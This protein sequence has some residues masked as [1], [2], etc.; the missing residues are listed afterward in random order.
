MKTPRYLIAED[1]PLLARAL[2]AHLAEL[3]SEAECA[4]FAA[5]GDEALTLVESLKPDVIFLD[6]RM[7]GRD[8]LQTAQ[9]LC[10]REAPPLIVFATAYDEYA[11]AAF[12]AAAVDY[13]LKPIDPER[14]IRCI[15]RLRERLA[16]PE[17]APALDQL[18]LRLQGLLGQTQA[19]ERL[20]FIRAGV[21]NTVKMIPVEQVIYFD[22][23]DKY[24]C[25]FTAEGEALIRTPL[26][27]LLAG[28]DPQQF[29]QIHR[30]TIVNV[31]SIASAERDEAGRIR[32]ALHGREEKLPVSR[33]FAHLFRQM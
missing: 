4:G 23:S 2:A 12:D 14:L 8:G 31:E 30:G 19:P 29:W 11:L 21:G 10:E 7:P 26:R 5:N 28:L 18:A 9:A 1:E 16:E 24:V 3:W 6:V 27:E 33:Q 32:L 17:T 25:V 20:R 13:L 22:A 15:A